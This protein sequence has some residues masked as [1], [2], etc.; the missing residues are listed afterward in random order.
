MSHIEVNLLGGLGGRGGG[1]PVTPM[2]T[3]FSGG[4][5][6]GRFFQTK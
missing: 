4:G 2:H 3:W 6:G 1:L 5:L